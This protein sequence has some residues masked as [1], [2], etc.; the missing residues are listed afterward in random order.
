[1]CVV[2]IHVY[3][4][5]RHAQTHI[6]KSYYCPLF[7]PDSRRGCPLCVSAQS[8]CVRAWWL[9]PIQSPALMS[10]KMDFIRS[11][12]RNCKRENKYL[13]KTIVVVL[14]FFLRVYESKSFRHPIS[15]TFITV[16]W[17]NYT[18][19]VYGRFE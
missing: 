3:T 9:R 13:E 11:D 12:G 6:D 10:Y 5:T 14:F 16:R 2:Y 19:N 15:P 18:G 17:F 4:H 7:L 1:M 8:E